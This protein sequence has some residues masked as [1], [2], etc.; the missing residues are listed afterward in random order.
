MSD[1]LRH[2]PA[3]LVVVP[4]LAAPAIVLVRHALAAWALAL[5]ATAAVAAISLALLLQTMGGETISYAFGSWPPPWGIEYRIDAANAFVAL[6]VSLVALF[7][8]PYCRASAAFE[9]AAERQYLLYALLMLCLCGLLGMAATGDA[10]NLFVF[11]EISSLSTYALVALGRD[12]RALTA[13]LQYL[14]LGT[15]GATFYVVGV[16]LLYLVTGSL[17]FADMAPRLAALEDRRAVHAALAF[18][19]AGI[20]LKVALFP[21]HA[22][23]PN[24]YTYAPSAVA[25]L[26]AGTATKVALYVLMR[27]YF[28]LLGER[29]VL[30]ELPVGEVLVALSLAAM[31]VASAAAIGQRDLKRLLAYSSV[32]QIGYITLGLGLATEAGLAAGLAHVF[33]HGITKAALFLL[34]GAMV[35]RMGNTRFEDLVGVAR[36]MPVASFAFVVGGLSLIGVPG[37]AGFA[38]KWALLTAAL[39]AGR[40]WIAAAIVASSLLAVAYV[41]RF[42][43]CAY[44]REPEHPQAPGG[45]VPASMM[46]PALLL[47]AL[48]VAAGLHASPVLEAARRAAAALMGGAP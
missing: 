48:V 15:L 28:G 2:L 19:T 43:E 12:R 37:T 47:V 9:V 44:F 7:V 21:L 18:I 4:L 40:P 10:F 20:G 13:A 39:E 38:S 46:A 41:W 32:G 42:V 8:I 3:L 36:H 34:A 23:L 45:A 30:V 24:A 6:A 11:L 25:A 16:G 33:N 17:N 14:L 5:A 1:A 27:V 29:L 35:L 31:F 22:W 26:L